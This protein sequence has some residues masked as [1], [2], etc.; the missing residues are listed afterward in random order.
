MYFHLFY[1]GFGLPIV[2]A[3]ASG[4]PVITSNDNA[5]AEVAGS[6]AEFV[7]SRDYR[8]IARAMEKMMTGNEV[9]RMKQEG[10]RNAKKFTWRNAAQ[11][12]AEVFREVLEANHP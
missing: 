3:M 1:E 2:E 7:N 10:I 8:D 6:A 11:G 4:C 12:Y 5:C 9:V